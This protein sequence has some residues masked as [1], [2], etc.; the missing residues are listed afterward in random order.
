MDG[1]STWV[2][3]VLAGY[4]GLVL[5]ISYLS[6]RNHQGASDFFLAGRKAPWFVVAF[7]MIGTSLSGVTFTSVPGAVQA[8]G[9]TYLQIVLGYLLGYVTIAFVLLPLYYRLRLTSIYMYLDQR[10]GPSSYRSGALLFLVSR[11]LGSAA[12]LYLVAV[13]FQYLVFDAWGVPFWVGATLTVVLILLYTFRGGMQTIVWTDTL[14]TAAMLG[15][16]GITLWYLRDAFSGQSLVQV[17]RAS[18]H[19]YWLDWNPQS[20][21]FFWKDLLA[22]AFIC[23]TMTGLDQ[24]QMQK[25]LSVK[26]LK[27]ARR[28]ML[29]YGVALVGVNL[30][31]VTLGVLLYQYAAR[32]GIDLPTR[33]DQVYAHLAFQALGP[34]V[35]LLFLV[36]LTAAAYSSADGSLTALTTSTCVDLLRMSPDDAS[37]NARRLRQRVHLLMAVMTLLAVLLFRWSETWQAGTLSVIDLV[38]GLATYTY[39]PLLGLYAFGMFTRLRVHDRWVPVVVVLAPLLSWALKTNETWLL[40]GYRI[41][42]E[43]LLING[44]LTFLGCLVLRRTSLTSPTAA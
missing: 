18:P 36:G 13:V 11:G 22:G 24:D 37:P 38:L 39:G 33:G 32:E 28:S 19:G 29:S 16:V 35:A 43:L 34:T 20:P 17:V 10:F 25:N 1:S 12:R 21:H 42:F 2:L 6:S 3:A 30:L 4:F 15:A 41:G 40:G 9:M 44:S 23:L 5:G 26:S 27:L 7:G 8:V 14:Q 31:F